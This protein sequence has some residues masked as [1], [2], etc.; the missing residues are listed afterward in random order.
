MMIWLDENQNIAGRPNENFARENMELFTLGYGNYSEDD[1]R[2]ARS[3]L[4]G[5][6][7][8]PEDSDAFV[9]VAKKH[10]NGVKTVLGHTGN[11]D[12]GDL[13]TIL[14]HSDASY[15]WISTRVWSSLR[16]DHHDRPGRQHAHDHVLAATQYRCAHDRDV[17]LTACSCRPR[18]SW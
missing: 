6:A 18:A 1:V 13:I 8:Q 11:F 12:G 5:L 2:E 17:H 14:T 7:L 10:D 16:K 3:L 4:H 15:R 9:E